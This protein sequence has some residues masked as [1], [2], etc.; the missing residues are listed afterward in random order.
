MMTNL[1]AAKL[2]DSQI[3][4]MKHFASCIDKERHGR[5]EVIYA[6]LF[7]AVAVLND[8]RRSRNELKRDLQSVK[9]FL[10][11]FVKYDEGRELAFQLGQMVLPNK[12]APIEPGEIGV[13]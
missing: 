4:L 12:E 1:E 11:T 2:A 7:L 6:A 10:N 9:A 8:G 3:E 13:N 5:G